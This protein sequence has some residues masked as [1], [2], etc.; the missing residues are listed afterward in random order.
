MYYSIAIKKKKKKK[1]K[2]TFFFS[3]YS[4][5]IRMS[6]FIWHFI[7]LQMYVCMYIWDVIYRGTNNFC[8]SIYLSSHR[9]WRRPFF[10]LISQ[11]LSTFA[12]RY[13]LF[14]IKKSRQEKTNISAISVFFLAQGEYLC[15]IYYTNEREEKKRR[16][17]KELIE[18]IH[19]R[20]SI[21]IYCQFISYAFSFEKV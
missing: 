9:F 7:V 5:S 19:L 14:Y 10:C 13:V 6:I 3:L 1:K 21:C 15:L 4:P 20:M 2:V 16:R 18:M 17:K 8:L 11:F 12:D